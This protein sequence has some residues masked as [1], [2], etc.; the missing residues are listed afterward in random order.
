MTLDTIG[1]S[2]DTLLAVYT[3]SSI[4]NLTVLA[5][6]DESGGGLSA[7]A[8]RDFAM[9]PSCPPATGPATRHASQSCTI[10]TTGRRGA[11]IIDLGFGRASAAG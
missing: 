9:Q 6:D 10:R 8:R 4:S 2:F 11:G 7:S 1:S 5:S 3:G